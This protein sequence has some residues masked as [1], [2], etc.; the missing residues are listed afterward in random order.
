MAMG[1]AWALSTELGRGGTVE[2]ILERYESRVKPA[3]EAKQRVG[4]RMARWFVPAS[5]RRIAMRDLLLRASVKPGMS[6]LLAGSISGTS[7]VE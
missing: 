7:I 5:A 2:Q 1:G 3:I 6:W 4:R